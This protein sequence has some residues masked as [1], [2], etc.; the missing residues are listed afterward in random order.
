MV[1][2]DVSIDAIHEINGPRSA[3]VSHDKPCDI[4]TP[5]S[6]DR[7][8]H[9]P[10]H[11]GPNIYPN[12]QLFSRLLRHARRGRIA[13]RDLNLGIEKT[14]GQ[15]LADALGLRSVLEESLGP[16][17]IRRIENGEE[18]YIGLLAAGGYE[19]AVGLLAVLALGAAVVLMSTYW[20]VI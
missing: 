16:D 12:S 6:V 9:F 2:P 8:H 4:D 15:L 19:F 17:V 3:D 14:Y 13:I 5:P 20:R 10:R 11:R 18:I 1:S 7:M